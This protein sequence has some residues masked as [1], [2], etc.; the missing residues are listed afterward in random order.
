MNFSPG[1]F[2]WIRRIDDAG[3]AVE[4]KL[5]RLGELSACAPL[6]LA[7]VL[8]VD[9]GESALQMRAAIISRPKRR[10]LVALSKLHLLSDA[11]GE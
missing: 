9:A 2:I 8:E 7:A 4:S 6:P 11:A 3:F 5:S 10:N 1:H